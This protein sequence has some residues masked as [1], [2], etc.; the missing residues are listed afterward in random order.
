[1]VWKRGQSGDGRGEWGNGEGKREETEHGLGQWE[2]GLSETEITAE[3][4]ARKRLR[5][6]ICLAGEE[7][8]V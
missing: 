2:L 7:G 8:K 5:G 6:M 3:M 1:M 4:W